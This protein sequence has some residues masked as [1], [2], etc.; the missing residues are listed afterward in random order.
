MTIQIVP[1]E[2]EVAYSE[3]YY[4]SLARTLGEERA[5]WARLSPEEREQELRWYHDHFNTPDDLSLWPPE[6]GGGSGNA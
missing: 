5:A 4:E 1:A 3:E 2:P 6:L